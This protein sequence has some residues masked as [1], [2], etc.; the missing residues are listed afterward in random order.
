MLL[1]PFAKDATD[2]YT[3]NFVTKYKAKYGEDTMNQFAADAYDAIY[4]IKAAAEKAG[5]TAD[6]TASQTCDVL[7]TA[8]TQITVDGVTGAGITW[9]ADGEP[10]K[11]P[12]AVVIENGAYK[13]L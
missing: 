2:T 10:S 12:K 6:M 9:A 1:T 7:K 5:I 3:V 8:M 11:A 13:A 4:T